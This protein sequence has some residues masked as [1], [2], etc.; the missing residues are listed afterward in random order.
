MGIFPGIFPMFGIYLPGY[1]YILRSWRLGADAVCVHLLSSTAQVY[2]KSFV[3]FWWQHFSFISC[4][5]AFC[6]ATGRHTQTKRF[7]MK[8]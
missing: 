4:S 2:E 7:E 3:F 5:S 1:N 8:R 6:S